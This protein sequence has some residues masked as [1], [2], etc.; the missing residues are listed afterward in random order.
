MSGLIT[1]ADIIDVTAKDW[2]TNI[3]ER[4]GHNWRRVNAM[5]A[6]QGD[7]MI[8]VPGFDF[9]FLEY[10][11]SGSH[12]VHFDGEFAFGDTWDG[13]L[14]PGCVSF[15]QCD[16]AFE[17]RAS[18]Q[19]TVMQAYIDRSVF[20]DCA[21]TLIKGDPDNVAARGFHGRFDPWLKTLVEALLEEARRPN[22]GTDLQADLLTQQ[23]AVAVLR[24]Q[25]AEQVK[26]V[27]VRTLADRDM[28]RV[29]AYLE[30]QME[31]IGGMDTVAG[32][33][34][35]DVYSFT[36]AF[37]ATTGQSPAQFLIERRIARVKQMLLGTAESLADIT[38][39]TG[40]S[41]QPHMTSTF[42]KHVGVSPG[43]W[44]KAIQQ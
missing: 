11:L 15:L 14:L 5:V 30:E 23:M 44:R 21:A 32:L 12:R 36:H 34:G 4:T 25:N 29:V 17:V 7:A 40:F 28:A 24:S 10:Y 20:S 27:K 8:A 43:K 19:G 3:S 22:I 9:F 16:S 13:V 6:D 38:Y 37:K 31:D 2:N 26:D 35:M 18:G 1:R 33:I 42:T 41:N 39:A